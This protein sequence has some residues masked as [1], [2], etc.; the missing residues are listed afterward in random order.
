MYGTCCLFPWSFPLQ[1]SYIFV[2]FFSLSMDSFNFSRRGSWRGIWNLLVYFYFSFA[3]WVSSCQTQQQHCC[4]CNGR[5]LRSKWH[6]LC[7]T[8]GSQ[9]RISCHHPELGTWLRT[10]WGVD[11]RVLAKADWQASEQTMKSQSPFTC[12]KNS[13]SIKGQR[14]ALELQEGGGCSAASAQHVH[15]ARRAV[16]ALQT[17]LLLAKCF[18]ILTSSEAA[19]ALAVAVSAKPLQHQASCFRLSKLLW[20]VLTLFRLL[21]LNLRYILS[22]FLYIAGRDGLF[23]KIGI[24]WGGLKRQG[25]DFGFLVGSTNGLNLRDDYPQILGDSRKALIWR[26]SWLLNMFFFGP[27][28]RSIKKNQRTSNQRVGMSSP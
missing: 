28:L 6:V 20:L 16:S 3:I 1:I 8:W 22:Q 23:A 5:W 13:K 2:H 12:K 21:T 9:F 26:Q 18:Q 10:P 17:R 19:S 27:P 25:K 24:G 15:A 7:L 11:C 14:R 4:F